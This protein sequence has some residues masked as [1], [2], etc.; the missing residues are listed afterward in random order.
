MR[1]AGQPPTA[2]PCMHAVV[3]AMSVAS[4]MAAMPCCRE[5]SQIDQAA[6]GPVKQAES[7]SA[8]RCVTSIRYAIASTQSPTTASHFRFGL[9][10][11]PTP[12]LPAR[13]AVPA[14]IDTT[15]H[16]SAVTTAPPILPPIFVSSHG[17]RAPPIG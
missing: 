13:P 2:K 9:K 16:A 12:A 7:V 4:T 10:S 17:L 6:V 5:S 11:P 14:A 15:F 1:C 3:P 8:V